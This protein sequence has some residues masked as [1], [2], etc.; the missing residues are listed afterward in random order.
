M[1]SPFFISCVTYKCNPVLPRTVRLINEI[2]TQSH[3]L[4]CMGWIIQQI[5]NLCWIIDTTGLKNSLICNPSLRFTFEKNKKGPQKR[6]IQYKFMQFHS[7]ICF[8]SSIRPLLLIDI[9]KANT[10]LPGFLTDSCLYLKNTWEWTIGL[11]VTQIDS[12]EH[13]KRNK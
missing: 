10:L 12:K 11:I 6:L 7:P 3:M 4:Q 9:L 13:R 1:S 8:V 2:Y 5:R